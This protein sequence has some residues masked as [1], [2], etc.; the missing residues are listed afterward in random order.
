MKIVLCFLLFSFPCTAATVRLTALVR[1]GVTLSNSIEQLYFPAGTTVGYVP[2]TN[3]YDIWSG[4][5]LVGNIDLSSMTF[6]SMD[7]LHVQVSNSGFWFAQE[8]DWVQWCLYGVTFGC[9][10]YGTGWG[11][12]MIRRTGHVSPEM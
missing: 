12:K 6:G 5:N 4:S 11:W 10:I 8:R 2:S 3:A 1:D 9:F 7:E